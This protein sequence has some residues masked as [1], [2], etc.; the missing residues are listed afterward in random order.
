[1]EKRHAKPITAYSG[2]SLQGQ[3][4]S[5]GLSCVCTTTVSSPSLLPQNSISKAPM[6]TL[7]HRQVQDAV[8]SIQ[9]IDESLTEDEQDF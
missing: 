6:K 3:L 7:N 2:H 9:V 5:F 1:M 4:Q 8:D